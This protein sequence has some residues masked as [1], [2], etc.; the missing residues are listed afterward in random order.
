MGQ[1]EGEQGCETS[2]KAGMKAG[3]K[4]DPGS[5][6]LSLG[7]DLVCSLPANGRACFLLCEQ[8]VLP[9]WPVDVSE[10]KEEDISDEEVTGLQELPSE[11]PAADLAEHNGEGTPD[12]VVPEEDPACVPSPY[13]WVVEA[14][15]Y[16]CPTSVPAFSEALDMIESVSNRPL[17]LW[18]VAVVGPDFHTVPVNEFTLSPCSLPWAS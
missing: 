1:S 14:T 2:Q 18:R 5:V 12:D 6:L 3:D 10:I 4:W 7:L 8:S 13:K 17:L 15:N 11:L 9:N 16:L